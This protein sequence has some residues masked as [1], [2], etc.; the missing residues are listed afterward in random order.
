M[1]HTD[2]KNKMDNIEHAFDKEA[3]W[4]RINK[5]EKKRRPIFWV[6]G[7]IAS[8]LLVC[9]LVFNRFYCTA[10]QKNMKPESKVRP[11][12][13][14]TSTEYIESQ[15]TVS[16]DNTIVQ[17][18]F[19]TKSALQYSNQSKS[20]IGI[21]SVSSEKKSSINTS[22]FD[23][24]VE[25]MRQSIYKMSIDEKT[26]TFQKTDAIIANG[27][28]KSDA[29][30]YLNQALIHEKVTVQNEAALELKK[31]DLGIS[32]VDELTLLKNKNI[33]LTYPILSALDLNLIT[34]PLYTK[35][36]LKIFK[37]NALKIYGSSGYDHHDFST[38]EYG[39]ARQKVE[40]SLEY[41]TI[42]LSYERV[43]CPSV[44]LKTMLS[45]VQSQTHL[46]AIEVDTTWYLNT[47]N[48]AI[49][50]WSGNAY[51]LYNEYQRL[52]AMAALTYS[53]DM[54][55]SW[56]LRPS[57][58]IGYML[59]H[60]QKG[61]IWDSEDNRV[62]LQSIAAYRDPAN[63][64]AQGDLVIEKSII[65]KYVIGIGFSI[66]SSRKLA[67]SY[68]YSHSIKPQGLQLYVGKQF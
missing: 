29:I 62:S 56:S 15:K 5:K 18:T 32:L 10:Y 9:S 30:G 19:A 11:N 68:N 57:L 67:N 47:Q 2:V 51:D 37:R 41:R 44:V 60:Q 28:N 14:A 34:L 25:Q 45:F 52:D 39:Q 16:L 21:G 42:S 7:V 4:S 26:S 12:I 36:P 66:Q 48:K 8:G 53:I 20:S 50:S 43:L 55:K 64:Y 61:D 59:L 49:K 6:I 1:K 22:D 35:K 40:K 31:G 58:G 38:S 46:T 17:D 27:Q 33:Y 65:N 63:V 54:G 23:K 13:K 3:L 24:S